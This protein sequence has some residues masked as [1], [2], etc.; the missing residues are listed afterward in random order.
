MEKAVDREYEYRLEGD[1][2]LKRVQYEVCS[3]VLSQQPGAQLC[4][5]GTL[6][7]LLVS[8]RALSIHETDSLVV[9]VVTDERLWEI[10]ERSKVITLKESGLGQVY[11]MVTPLISG[12]LPFPSVQLHAAANSMRSEDRFWSDSSD[13]PPNPPLF[14]FERT[15]GKQI[16][17]LGASGGDGGSVSSRGEKRSRI[18]EKLQKLFD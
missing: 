5:V 8:I 9:T 11:M 16:R 13:S 4:R 18:K 3:Q 17:V 1:L 14:T 15:A 12:F 10:G 6:C 7:H 2:E